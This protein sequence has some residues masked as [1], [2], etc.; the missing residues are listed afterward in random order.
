MDISTSN[1]IYIAF[2]NYYSYKRSNDLT[3]ILYLF[4]T[5]LI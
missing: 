3:D 2:L 5:Y 1:S 4:L